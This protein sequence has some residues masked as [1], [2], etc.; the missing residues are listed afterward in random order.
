MFR[1]E[2]GFPPFLAPAPEQVW[3]VLDA[4]KAFSDKVRECQFQT[5]AEDCLA[6]I[7]LCKEDQV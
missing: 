2:A 7:G 3:K 1:D 5:R 6:I 4:M